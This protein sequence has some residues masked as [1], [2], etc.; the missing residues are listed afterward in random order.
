[1]ARRKGKE[2]RPGG[3]VCIRCRAAQQTARSPGLPLTIPLGVPTYWS[4]EQAVAVYEL[5]DELR[6]LICTMYQPDLYD[7]IRR[8]RQSGSVDPVPITED[9]LPF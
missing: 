1:M 5:I 7:Q 2:R 3:A 4:P 9:D 6:D 8:D